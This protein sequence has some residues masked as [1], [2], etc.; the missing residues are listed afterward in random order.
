MKARGKIKPKARNGA[1]RQVTTGRSSKEAGARVVRIRVS[2]DEFLEFERC[3]AGRPLGGWAREVLL[4]IAR[5]EEQD[6]RS[7]G[8]RGDGIG[9]RATR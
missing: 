5:G 6:L 2:A 8:A 3:A 4:A 1:G 7:V 9:T